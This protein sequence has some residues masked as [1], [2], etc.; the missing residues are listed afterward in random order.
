MGVVLWSALRF[1]EAYQAFEKG[2]GSNLEE[3]EFL[4]LAGL[5]GC[6]D[7]MGLSQRQ[8]DW[9]L[10]AVEEVPRNPSHSRTLGLYILA[11]LAA[12]RFGDLHLAEDFIEGGEALQALPDGEFPLFFGGIP[13]QLA[14]LRGDL[15]K[16][17]QVLGLFQGRCARDGH[18]SLERIAWGLLASVHY[19]MGQLE[20]AQNCWERHLEG[21]PLPYIVAFKAQLWPS[22]IGTL[23][24]LGKIDKAERALHDPTG[25]G[26]DS[27]LAVEA[28]HFRWLLQNKRHEEAWA[29]LGDPPREL[30][31]SRYRYTEQPRYWAWITLWAQSDESSAHA[32]A[33]RW[34]ALLEKM[35]KKSGRARDRLEAKLLR[36]AIFLKARRNKE[37]EAEIQEALCQ[38]RPLG[39]VAVF[40][41]S[42][43]QVRRL[44]LRLDPTLSRAASQWRQTFSLSP[45]ER[46]ILELLR[47]GASNQQIAEHCFLSLH[48][49]KWYNQRIFKKLGLKTRAEILSLPDFIESN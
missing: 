46:E 15:E 14:F 39:Y 34:L 44:C 12:V 1:P 35:A 31:E 7:A 38:G 27:G 8:R 11:T 16:A 5:T 42:P 26:L 19:E 25:F 23:S 43:V 37:A 32:R 33:H 41:D 17:V 3:V 6:C 9:Y 4:C 49:V 30:D 29:L 45:R 18:Q 10:R 22:Y 28:V 2:L 36:A 21:E 40:L 20:Q 47:S 13:G 24:A 48:T